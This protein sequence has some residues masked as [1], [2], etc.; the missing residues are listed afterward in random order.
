[1]SGQDATPGEMPGFPFTGRP[2]SELDELLDMILNGQSVP[3]DAPGEIHDL[4]ETL[5]GLDGPGEPDELAGEAAVV[6]FALA[7][8]ASPA[9]VS[10]ARPARRKPPRRTVPRS[11]RVAAAL[12]VAAIPL[13][14]TAAAY[15]GVL[16]G[17]VQDV[18]HHVIHAPLAHRP[19]HP[20]Q[21][22]AEDTPG[23]GSPVAPTA[24]RPASPE[25]VKPKGTPKPAKSKGAPKPAKS[26][27]PHRSPKPK[28]TAPKQKAPKPTAPAT[29]TP[30]AQPPTG[31]TA[32]APATATAIPKHEHKR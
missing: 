23:H 10:P 2:A 29:V 1:M 4:A 16:P 9:G 28:P 3:P 30:K 18:A 5:A 15:T 26:A 12:A 8:T 20:R 14:G 11:M 6:R 21:H 25:P 24:S 13:G 31:P 22:P 7:R 27:K 32:P 17:P 19:G